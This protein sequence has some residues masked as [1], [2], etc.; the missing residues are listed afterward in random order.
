LSTTSYPGA[1][2]PAGPGAHHVRSW[3]EAEVN[4]ARWMQYWG[5]TDATVT[6]GGT[7][8]GIDVRATYALAQV[9]FLASSVGRPDLQRLIGAAAAEP[10]RQLIFFTGSDYSVK[11]VEF[12]DAVGMALFTYG[13]DGSM[14]PINPTARTVMQR[15]GVP[16]QPVPAWQPSST[17]AW[18]PAQTPGHTPTGLGAATP[19]APTL[20][21][22]FKA[23]GWYFVV[24]I[25]TAG[26]F[27]GVPFWHA[28]VRLGRPSLWRPAALY[29]AAGIGFLVVSDLIPKDA[30]G[31]PIG[32]GAAVADNL[33][34]AVALILIIAACLQLRPIRREVYGGDRPKPPTDADPAVARALERRTKRHEAR[35][36][37]EKDRGLARELGIGRPDLGRGYDDGGLVDLNSAPAEL[38]AQV[39]D[40]DLQDAHRIVDARDLRG[41]RFFSMG[42][43]FLD[44]ALPLAAEEELRE[45]GVTL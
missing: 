17:P 2:W 40:M 41:G 22:R 9:K 21:D 15:G 33:L 24:P 10:G 44:V 43:V 38:I 34:V 25:V 4:A 5:F 19:A 45:R 39:C 35:S 27:T 26:V 1:A 23:G 16:S 31:E 8:G 28:A 14:T 29:T 37:T 32:R 13:L 12:A 42:E 7:D 6:Q 36:L 18:N 3:Q 20:G 11:A 30:A